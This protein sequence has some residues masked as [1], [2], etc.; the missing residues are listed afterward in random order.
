MGRGGSSGIRWVKSPRSLRGKVNQ[1]HLAIVA[2]I[3][4]RVDLPA[5]EAEEDLGQL[6]GDPVGQVVHVQQ[7]AED[8][9]ALLPVREAGI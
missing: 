3:D 8:A 7:I 2:L 4:Q 5:V 9:E 6:A 1:T